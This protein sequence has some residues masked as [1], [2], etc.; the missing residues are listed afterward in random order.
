MDTRKTLPYFR[1]LAASPTP[2][3]VLDFDGTLTGL[4]VGDEVCDRFADPAWHAWDEKLSRREISLPDAQVE[5]W[6]L[7][8]GDRDAMV[9]YACEVG[10]LREGAAEILEAGVRGELD[11]VLASGGFD[12][13]VE[14]ILAPWIARGAFRARYYNATS[15]ENGRIAVRFPHVD[16]RCGYCAVCK[17]KVTERHRDTNRPV[18]F[19]GDGQSDLCAAPLANVVYAVRG[20]QLAR[21]CE[22]KGIAHVAFD[23]LPSPSEIREAA[24]SSFRRRP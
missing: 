10:V 4:D 15:F 14:A 6:A 9:G 7:C 12:F 20:K 3:V 11:L 5:M 1:G 17:G 23:V 16:L 22:E 24:S 2:L 19:L 21:G 18:V 8:R 13:Y